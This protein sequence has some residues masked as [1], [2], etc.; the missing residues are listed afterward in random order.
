MTEPTAQP[1]LAVRVVGSLGAGVIVI[2]AVLLLLKVTDYVIGRQYKSSP[3]YPEF[4][5]PIVFDMYPY[6][7]GHMAANMVWDKEIHIGQMGYWYPDFDFNHPPKKEA[8]EVRIVLIGGSGAQGQGGTIPNSQMLYAQIEMRLNDYGKHTGKK[9][10]VIN[11][12]MGGSRTY[13]N[14]VDLNQFAHKLEPDM[15]LTYSGFNDWVL[16]TYFENQSDFYLSKECLSS[17]DKFTPKKNPLVSLLPNL[18]YT[19]SRDGSATLRTAFNRN[20]HFAGPIKYRGS[21]HCYETEKQFFDQAVVPLY[22]HSLRSIKRDFPG[23]PVMVAWQAIENEPDE[24]GPYGD[25][26]KKFGDN[27]YNEMYERAKAATQNYRDGKWIYFNVHRMYDPDPRLF[28]FHMTAEAQGVVGDAIAQRLMLHFDANYAATH[29]DVAKAIEAENY[30]VERASEAK[31]VAGAP[32]EWSEDAY[33]LAYPEIKALV[34]AGQYG[35]GWSYFRDKGKAEG[36]IEGSPTRWNE[37]GYLVANPDVAYFV[38]R[39]AYSS[40]YDHWL[41]AGKTERRRGGAVE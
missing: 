18:L 11:M 38:R 23:I 12:A 3:L 4:M 33:L 37:R 35:S 2:V 32:P 26:K 40:G 39:G 6:S 31:K 1:S 7:V 41:K 21:S 8:N 25:P 16:A 20:S 13:H 30:R 15:I 10:R 5:Q 29:P 19:N 24:F 17:L 27:Y 9:F 34:Q 22:I 28:G 36:K 14:F